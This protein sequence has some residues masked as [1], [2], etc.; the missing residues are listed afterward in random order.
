MKKR[1]FISVF[2]ILI[3]VHSIIYSCTSFIISGKYTPDGKPILFKNRDTDKM[4]NSLVFF[5][6]GKYKY[7]GLVD[8]NHDWKTMIWG[9][10]NEKGFAI[11]NTAAYNN[12]IGD[13]SKV[14]DREGII[15]KLAL[16]TCQSLQD[17]ENLLKTMHKPM[18]ADSNFGVIDAFGGAAYYETG[19]YNFVKYDVNDPKVAPEGFLVR[20]NYSF[21]ADIK[22]G[23]GFC[24][25][26]TAVIALNM[27]LTEN[28]LS[29]E[30]LFNHLSRNLYHSLTKTDLAANIPERRDV[31]DYNFF[32]DYIPRETSASAI[33][34]VGAKD[35]KHVEQTVMWSIIGFPLTSV[36]VPVWLSAGN[37]LPKAVSMNINLKS[38]I[39]LAALKFKA[40][41]FPITYDRGFNYINLSVLLNK[42]Q[43]GYMQLLHPVEEKIFIQA[44]KLISDMEKGLKSKNDILLFYKWLDSFLADEYM[45]LFGINLFEN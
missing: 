3:G 5:T 25:Y 10:Y 42:E 12:N 9:G 1:F 11:I 6:D 24:R 28:N 8:G 21:N 4:Q 30:Y 37:Q 32:I 29:P 45:K 20:T 23:F 33:M 19:N 13:S 39:C 26:N 38:P 43:N 44:N 17:F 14:K 36:A 18:G 2:F 40:E 34:I 27:A 31:P 22:K 35:L 7:L 15:M 41:C 16:Q